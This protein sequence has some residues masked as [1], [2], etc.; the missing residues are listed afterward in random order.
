MSNDLTPLE[1]GLSHEMTVYTNHQQTAHALGNPGVH[2]LATIFLIRFVEE[3]CGRSV[4]S[5][6]APNE[7]TVGTRVNLAHRAPA[8]AGAALDIRSTLIQIKAHHLVFETAVYENDRLLM[9]G[10]HKRA[11]INTDT[12]LEKVAHDGNDIVAN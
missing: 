2:V 11:I 3:C 4:M 12:F 5:G 8:L 1:V 7:A 6:L 9:D 10:I